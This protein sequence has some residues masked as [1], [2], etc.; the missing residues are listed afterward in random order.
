MLE[1]RFT[2]QLF[3]GTRLQIDCSDYY[4]LNF[5]TLYLRYMFDAHTGPVPYPPDPVKPYSR[6]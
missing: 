4:A 3:G 2:P 6:F 1:Y 5:A